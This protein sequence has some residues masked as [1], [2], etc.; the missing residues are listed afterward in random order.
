MYP[1]AGERVNHESITGPDPVTAVMRSGMTAAVT[2]AGALG[3]AGA[4]GDA[5]AVEHRGS[6]W[7]GGAV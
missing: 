7:G 1:A 2:D 6:T 4:P 5:G 3:N